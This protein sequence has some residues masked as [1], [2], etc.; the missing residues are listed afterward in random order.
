MR[1]FTNTFLCIWRS[2]GD[3]LDRYK[4]YQNIASSPLVQNK[5]SKEHSFN[6]AISKLI[7]VHGVEISPEM[8]Q[9]LTVWLGYLSVISEDISASQTGINLSIGAFF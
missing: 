1:L 6:A 3:H 4:S 2:F 9:T 5:Y 8:C 7:Q